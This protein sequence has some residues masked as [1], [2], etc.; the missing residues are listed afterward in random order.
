MGWGGGC[1]S[2]VVCRCGRSA[3]RGEFRLLL[4][5]L[6][7]VNLKQTRLTFKTDGTSPISFVD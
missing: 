5:A 7:E 4:H 6:L 3:R 1:G 2:G